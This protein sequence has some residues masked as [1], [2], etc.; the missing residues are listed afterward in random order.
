MWRPGWSFWFITLVSITLVLIG[1]TPWA[2]LFI[3]VGEALGDGDL[4]Y[5]W[6]SVIPL[7]VVVVIWIFFVRRSRREESQKG[8]P[9]DSK[10]A[11]G[12]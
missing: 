4:Y 10:G 11:S 9:E 6:L 3:M 2:F 1:V 5:H 8:P 7:M 12:G